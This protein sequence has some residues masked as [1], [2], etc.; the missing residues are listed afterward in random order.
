MSK[1]VLNGPPPLPS[2]PQKL[3]VLFS[4]HSDLLPSASSPVHVEMLQRCVEMHQGRILRSC[5]DV[6]SQSVVQSHYNVNTD[7]IRNLKTE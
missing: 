5:Y 6:P 7:I 3:T 2:T 4:V 1:N